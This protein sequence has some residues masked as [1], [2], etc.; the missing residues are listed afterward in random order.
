MALKI[1]Q[2]SPK[3]KGGP[4]RFL[5]EAVWYP[6]SGLKAF[7]PGKGTFF[8]GTPGGEGVWEGFVSKEYKTGGPQH[9]KAPGNYQR[10]TIKGI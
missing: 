1:T 3:T 2:G 7:L 6:L 9:S 8:K 4:G 5:G 10:K